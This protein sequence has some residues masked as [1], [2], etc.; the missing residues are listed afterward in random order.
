MPRRIE[1]SDIEYGGVANGKWYCNICFAQQLFIKREVNDY[2]E[3][4]RYN[5]PE[6][7][8]YVDPATCEHFKYPV[9]SSV[10][11]T[12]VTKEEHTQVWVC[13]NCNTEQRETYEHMYIDGICVCGHRQDGYNE[14][15]RIITIENAEYVMT[16]SKEETYGGTKEIALVQLKDSD[17]VQLKILSDELSVLSY[18]WE[19]KLKGYP[20]SNKNPIPSKEVLKIS[21]NGSKVTDYVLEQP[22]YILRLEYVTKTNTKPVMIEYQIY[23][24]K[25]KTVEA[26]AEEE[27]VE[28]PK[29]EEQKEENSIEERDSQDIIKIENAEYIMTYS[30]EEAYGGTR[31]KEIALVQLKDSD[32]VQLKILSDELS[33]LSYEWEG[34]LKGY[35]TSNKNPIPSKEVLKI[36]GNGSKVTDYVL[37]QPDY[38]LR[39]EYVT[40]TNTKPVM[41]EYQIY[42]P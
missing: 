40:K 26:I 18:E 27:K 1:N 11:F 6:P 29:E 9:P 7:P 35:P 25:N 30:K 36:S 39:L 16:Y 2:V 13:T 42:L 12:N 20:T 21:G 34:K 33:V 22:D 37:E 41:I 4:F 10:R 28:E 19:G 23:L 32:S 14:D 24:P 17:S 3:E 38:I 31:T 8:N 15:G 5:Y